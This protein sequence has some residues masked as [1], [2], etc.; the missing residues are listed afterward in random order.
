MDWEVER[1]VSAP[2]PL[3]WQNLIREDELQPH[4]SEMSPPKAGNFFHE[5][6]EKDLEIPGTDWEGA[7]R[8]EEE[9]VGR[10]DC[11]DRLDGVVYEFK[12]KNESGMRRAPCSDDISQIQGY[13]DGLDRDVGFLIYVNRD[14]LEVEEYPVFR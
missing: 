6:L 1:G 13:L 3:D 10:Y 7:V 9:L 12:T 2:D 8:S 4:L 11:Y 14:S 5:Y